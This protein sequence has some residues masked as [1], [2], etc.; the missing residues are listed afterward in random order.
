MHLTPSINEYIIQKPASIEINFNSV[1]TPD[2]IA[3]DP[4]DYLSLSTWDQVAIFHFSEVCKS[5]DFSDTKY[6]EGVIQQYTSPAHNDSWYEALLVHT[7]MCIV[8]YV[9]YPNNCRIKLTRAHSNREIFFLPEAAITAT[10]LECITV[11]AKITC[12]FSHRR[13]IFQRCNRS[14]KTAIK[15]HS[16][17]HTTG[18]VQP[19]CFIK[20]VCNSYRPY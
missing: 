13:T 17:K 20:T 8:G 9:S 16:V 1:V 12:Q 14:Y 15:R 5:H 10:S 3:Q 19:H 6:K 7:C 2:S 18:F 4:I 11:D